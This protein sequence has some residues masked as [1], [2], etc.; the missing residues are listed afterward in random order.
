M[1]P[2]MNETIALYCLA[3]TKRGVDLTVFLNDGS[4]ACWGSQTAFTP[5]Y[6]GWSGYERKELTGLNEYVIDVRI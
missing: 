1:N 3:K 6:G 4:M 2:N 5:T